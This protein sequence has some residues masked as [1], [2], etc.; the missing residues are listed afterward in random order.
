MN[1]VLSDIHGRYDLYEKMLEKIDLKSFDSFYIIGDV[2]DRGQDG[3]RILLDIMSR[4]NIVLIIGN[5]EDMMYKAIRQG[6]SCDSKG[7]ILLTAESAL[8]L[9]NGGRTTLNSYLRLGTDEK[10]K[11]L[12]YLKTCPVCIPQLKA[13]GRRFYLVHAFPSAQL[14]EGQHLYGDY[15]DDNELLHELLWKR[16][17]YANG[18][19]DTFNLPEDTEAII[20]HTITAYFEPG[21]RNSE[22]GCRIFFGKSFIAM[23]CGAGRGGSMARLG[24]LR[25]EDRKE[26]YVS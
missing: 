12:E 11:I 8:W 5:H 14:K 2:I 7:D 18:N 20:G 9:Y 17:T 24:C 26:F 6:F 23:D 13:G 19:W 3:I 4:N 1:Y 25:L 15:V 21:E 10:S 22:D 16:L